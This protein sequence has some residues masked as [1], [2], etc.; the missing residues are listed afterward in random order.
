MQLSDWAPWKLLCVPKHLGTTICRAGVACSVTL[1]GKCQGCQHQ[2]PRT[3]LQTKNLILSPSGVQKSEIRVPAGGSGWE[4]SD[5]SQPPVVVVSPLTDPSPHPPPRGRV[6]LSLRDSVLTRYF[7]FFS[8]DPGHIRRE[9]SNSS[10]SV[11]YLT[12]PV[13]TLFQIRSQVTRT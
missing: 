6:V 5:L 2:T 8:K 1:V 13:T 11:S 9:P 12:I 10:R 3:G 7:S 4:P